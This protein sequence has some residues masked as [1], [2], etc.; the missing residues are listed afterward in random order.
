MEKSLG[1]LMLSWTMG[2]HEFRKIKNHCS[3]ANCHYSHQHKLVI[4]CK[5]PAWLSVCLCS[6]NVS[7][8]LKFGATGQ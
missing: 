6:L 1:F 3:K 2:R 4:S 7:V 5:C 8:S